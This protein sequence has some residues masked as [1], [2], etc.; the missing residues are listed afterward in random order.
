[1]IQYDANGFRQ[2][3]ADSI[4][5]ETA[6]AATIHVARHRN[7]YTCGDHAESVYFIESG[8][9]KLLVHSPAGKE[10]L[11]AIHTAGD[12]FGESC[13][14]KR[15]KR[16]ETATAMEDSVVKRIPCLN[17][18]MCLSSD[19]RLEGF[20]QYLV[21]RVAE[22]QQLIA[23]LATVDS[24]QRLG[25][26]L[27]LLAHKLGKHDLRSIRIER[28]VTHQEL[29]EMVGTTRPRISEFMHKF[30]QLGLIE[31]SAEH[32]LIVKEKNLS[33]Y[34]DRVAGRSGG[35]LRSY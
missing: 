11:L 31:T 32:H 14:A 7:V 30:R 10:C 13:L 5:R 26:T 33:D 18:F 3:L 19:S 35:K 22:Q 34:L 12:I 28:K 15:G 17:F 21:V 8:Q 6:S 2:H 25:S 1:M 29:S 4:R 27:L 20:A 23:S 16:M 9:I 24:E